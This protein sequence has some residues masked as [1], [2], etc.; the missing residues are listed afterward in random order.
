MMALAEPEAI[1]RSR[2]RASFDTHSYQGSVFYEKLGYNRF[3]EITAAYPATA[4][5]CSESGSGDLPLCRVD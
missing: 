4:A 2:N 5:S 3:G 1:R